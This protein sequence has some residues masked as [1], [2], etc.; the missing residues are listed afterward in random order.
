MNTLLEAVSSY[1]T[2]FLTENLS[3]QLSFHNIGHT[4]EVVDAAYEI[5]LQCNLSSEEINV[6]QIAAWFHD[7]GYAHVYKG[8]EDESKKIAKSFLENF[9]CA[10]SFI[11]S[12]LNCIESTKY[13]QNPSSLIEK[14]LCDADMYHLTRPNYSKYEKALRLEFEKYLGLVCSDEDWRIKNSNFF[15]SHEY[16]TEYGQKILSKFKEINLQLINGDK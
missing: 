1:V 9:S 4:Y 13:P 11:E 6:L 15:Q 5:G 12:V 16:Y 10:K 7:C 3:D 14:V 8:H 2:A